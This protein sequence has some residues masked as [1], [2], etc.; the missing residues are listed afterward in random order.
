MMSGNHHQHTEGVSCVNDDSTK[1]ASPS[2]PRLA[3]RRSP[4]CRLIVDGFGLALVLNAVE[5]DVDLDENAWLTIPSN[6]NCPQGVSHE[7]HRCPHYD[8][9]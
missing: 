8:F 2:M 3:T 6:L 9:G 5:P 1:T 7:L 4:S